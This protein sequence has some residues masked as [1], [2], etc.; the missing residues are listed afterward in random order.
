MHTDTTPTIPPI[1]PCHDQFVLTLSCR[2]T[3]GIVHAVS[4][5]L[6]Q[7]GCNIIDSQQF[8]D[9]TGE[10]ATGLFFMRVHFEAPPQ[11]A[12]VATLDR[13][14]HHVRGQF[15]MDARLHALGRRSRVLLMVSRQ[16]HCL[17][18]LLFRWKSGL[19][20]FEIPAIV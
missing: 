2:D 18:D 7:A 17:N 13:L 16:G 20:E 5:L 1:M 10:D 14:L 8:G 4:G 12:D 9:L 11:L 15:Q 6:Y 3:K 19:L